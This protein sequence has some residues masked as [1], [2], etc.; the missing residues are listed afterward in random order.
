MSSFVVFYLIYSNNSNSIH[1]SWLSL[2][3]IVPLMS[4]EKI[5]FKVYRWRSIKFTVST[6]FDFLRII[7][8]I[9]TI[10]LAVIEICFFIPFPHWVICLC[11][12]AHV[13]FP[14]TSAV[15]QKRAFIFFFFIIQ[16]PMSNSGGH[17]GFL[18]DNK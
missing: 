14:L 15:S 9:L 4:E 5:F 11:P 18:M 7:Q 17:L 12:M 1:V 6:N 2:V 16:S 8:W 10:S 13:W 3:H